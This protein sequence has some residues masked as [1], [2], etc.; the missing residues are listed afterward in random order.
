MAR[1]IACNAMGTAPLGVS[2][3]AQAYPV[4]STQIS[5]APSATAC[6]SGVLLTTPP[7]MRSRP[8][9]RTGGN[10]A[11][12]AA[13]AAMASIG[14]PPDS[15]TSL[16]VSTSVAT[17]CNGIGAS[18]R[19]RNSKCSL[20]SRRS[21]ESDTRLWRWPMKPR[22]PTERFVGKTSLRDSDRHK[23]ARPLMPSM[24]GREDIHPPFRAPTD[25]P[26]IRSGAIPAS[27]KASSMPT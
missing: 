17:T 22:N 5:V 2:V 27:A 4:G 10:T 24:S 1:V 7:S 8:S 26:T 13:L 18:S 19:R 9:I 25:V 3:R 14:S 20:R 11:G 21:P 15:R 23:S 16:P 12:T 6:E